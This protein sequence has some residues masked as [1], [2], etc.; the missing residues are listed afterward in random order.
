MG[1]IEGNM[2]LLDTIL[3]QMVSIYGLS[4]QCTLIED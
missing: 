1:V 2:V 3:E 4:S